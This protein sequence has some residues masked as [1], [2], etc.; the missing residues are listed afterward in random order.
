[1][2]T[3]LRPEIINAAILGFEQQ[4]SRIDD[5]I[6]EL[7]AMLDG[8]TEPTPRHAGSNYRETQDF[9]AAARRRMALGQKARWAKLRRICVASAN[10][11]AGTA[12]GKTEIECRWQ[13]RNHRRHES[14]LGSY[15]GRSCE[16][17]PAVAEKSGEEMGGEERSGKEAPEEGGVGSRSGGNGSVRAGKM[18]G[19]NQSRGRRRG[20]CPENR[21]FHSCRRH[22]QR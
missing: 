17:K 13:S 8:G 11:H 1:M 7:R 14:T 2:P 15:P 22:S 6:A 16:A 12:K 20:K 18:P 5:Q 19:P 3:R 4:K 9:R 10:R 21:C